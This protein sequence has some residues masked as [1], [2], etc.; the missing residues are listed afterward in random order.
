MRLKKII[1]KAIKSFT[2]SVM[3]PSLYYY[4]VFEK[5]NPVFLYSLQE[6]AS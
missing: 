4:T 6:K 1:R 2:I 5:E 3:S